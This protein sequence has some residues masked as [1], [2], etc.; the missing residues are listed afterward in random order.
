MALI[1]ST[2]A[3]SLMKDAVVLDLGDLRRQGEE[4]VRRAR[5]EAERIVAEAR[6]ER[7]R[8]L[9]GARE[10]GRAEGMAKGLEEG[11]RL[12]IEQAA[13]AAIADHHAQVEGLEGAW[14]AALGAFEAERE[15]LVQAATRDV[16]ALA[17]EVARRVVKRTVELDPGVVADQLRAVLGVVTR[18]T[19]LVIAINPLDRAL[20]ERALPGLVAA[21]PAVR[22][23]HLVDDPGV[24]RGGCVARTRGDAA[25]G[26]AGGGE[27]NADIPVQLDRIVEA[28]L[29]GA[30]GGGGTGGE[31]LSGERSW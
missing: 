25:L 9:A 21:M 7:E 22:H 10:E 1:K 15:G 5:I 4:L 13:A 30:A 14:R 26:D 6:A 29:P 18:P 20:V 12:G 8:I 17:L 24:S 3:V 28:L 19:E 27:I 23:A 11:T 2:T 31:A 16:I